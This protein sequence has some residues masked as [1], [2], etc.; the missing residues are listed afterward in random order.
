M[1]HIEGGSV[2]VTDALF[3]RG[4]RVIRPRMTRMWVRSVTLR[5]A[6]R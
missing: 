1:R 5:V 3:C 2:R 6:E 4:Q